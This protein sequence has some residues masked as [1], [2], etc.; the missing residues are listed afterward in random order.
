MA[1]TTVQLAAQINNSRNDLQVWADSTLQNQGPMVPAFTAYFN[2]LQD[3]I[4]QNGGANPFGW[5]DVTGLTYANGIQVVLQ[6]PAQ[7]A[8]F[9]DAFNDVRAHLGNPDF[10][11]FQAAGA[12]LRLINVLGQLG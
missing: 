8:P 12:S 4:T 9:N 1:F 5:N 2:N 7:T 10:R 11:L 6:G 3:W